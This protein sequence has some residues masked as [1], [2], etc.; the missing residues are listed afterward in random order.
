ML[1]LVAGFWRVHAYVSPPTDVEVVGLSE[2]YQLTE[3]SFR[4]VYSARRQDLLTLRLVVEATEDNLDAK[5][6]MLILSRNLNPASSGRYRYGYELSDQF[7]YRTEHFDG[8]KYVYEFQDR[9]QGV[10]LEEFSGNL[11]GN[12]QAGLSFDLDIFALD[13]WNAPVDVTIQGLAATDLYSVYPEPTLVEQGLLVYHF[14][15]FNSPNGC[16]IMI[17]LNAVDVT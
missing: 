16:G 12:N 3:A 11:F 8:Y 1:C 7:R 6:I 14:D 10:I 15:S 4:F 17:N 5:K 9:E 13:K 2:G